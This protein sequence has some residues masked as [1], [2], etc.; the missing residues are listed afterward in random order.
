MNKT[1]KWPINFGNNR[2]SNLDGFKFKNKSTQFSCT[3][4]RNLLKLKHYLNKNAYE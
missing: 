1:Q 3:E 2:D 4:F